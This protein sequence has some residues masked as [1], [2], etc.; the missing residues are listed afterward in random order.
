[1]NLTLNQLDNLVHAWVKQV[2]HLL[3]KACQPGT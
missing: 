3:T 1:L 2:S